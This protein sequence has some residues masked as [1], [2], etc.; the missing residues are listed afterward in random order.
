MHIKQ[1]RMCVACRKKQNQEN[2]L[3]VAKL[4]DSY[5]ID[6]KQVLQG[7]GAYICNCKECIV[8]TIKKRL[9]NRSFK[10]NLNTSIYEE[11]GEYEQNN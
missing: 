11:L 7:R 2:M 6:I 3:R 4:N 8:Q 5:V 9:L 1:E 10:T